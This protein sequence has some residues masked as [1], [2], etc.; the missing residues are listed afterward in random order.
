[1]QA[2][3]KHIPPRPNGMVVTLPDFTVYAERYPIQIAVGNVQHEAALV[4]AGGPE[5]PWWR[6]QD[7]LEA[8]RRNRKAATEATVI[9]AWAGRELAAVLQAAG[10]QFEI[11]MPGWLPPPALRLAALQVALTEIR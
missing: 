3:Q 7:T 4:Y 6:W 5:F 1:M 10:W 9:R 2:A 8:G 11:A